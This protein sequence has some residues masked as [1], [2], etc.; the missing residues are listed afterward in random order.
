MQNKEKNAEIN[1]YR[2]NY[3]YSRL[4]EVKIYN[5]S[6]YNPYFPMKIYLQ[7]QLF[8]LMK[9]NTIITF[10]ENLRRLYNGKIYNNI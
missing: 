5:I 4:K 10:S 8:L 2:Q 6:I 1:N 7:M 9:N 3:I